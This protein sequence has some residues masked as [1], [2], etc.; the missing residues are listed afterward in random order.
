MNLA[1][2]IAVIIFG[3]ATLA[4]YYAIYLSA[5][6]SFSA[7]S[8]SIEGIRMLRLGMLGHFV[9]LLLLALTSVLT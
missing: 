6:K 8:I 1:A 2:L 3:S 5:K 4:I 7:G 9:I